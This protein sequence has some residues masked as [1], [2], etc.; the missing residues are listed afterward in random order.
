MYLH[1]RCLRLK[2]VPIYIGTLRPKYIL[3]GLM[4]LS[5]F[6]GSLKGS[7]RHLWWFRVSGP[8]GGSWDLV[9]AA[10][11]TLIWV[12]ITYKYSYLIYNPSY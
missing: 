3:Y 1:S 8:H 10:I 4:E 7:R 12:T 2:G 5:K 9:S 11:S 6:K